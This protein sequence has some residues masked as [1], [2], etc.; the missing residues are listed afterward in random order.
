[1]VA[2][3]RKP[4]SAERH[5]RREVRFRGFVGGTSFCYRWAV[6]NSGIRRCSLNQVRPR[7]PLKGVAPNQWRAGSVEKAV[8]DARML[9]AHTRFVVVLD[10][11][12]RCV[13]MFH[14]EKGYI[15]SV[16]C[17]LALFP[18]EG[19][20]RQVS[21]PYA[22]MRRCAGIP[23]VLHERHMGLRRETTAGRVSRQAALLSAVSRQHS[24]FSLGTMSRHAR[25]GWYTGGD[26]VPSTAVH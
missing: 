26:G 7:E 2:G 25:C 12:G 20:S 8:Y 11:A 4:A 15:A 6:S 1:M 23:R 3:H 13:D 24:L 16:A 21:A 14:R 18:A 17:V 19:H 9:R 5:P 10:A 22:V